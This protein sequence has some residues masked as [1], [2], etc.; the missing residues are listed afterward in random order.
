MHEKKP[1]KS[2]TEKNSP[3]KPSKTI[4]RLQ[5]P[6]FKHYLYDFWTDYY[7]IMIPLLS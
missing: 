6:R 7:T 4:S 5:N 3:S 2:K 1:L